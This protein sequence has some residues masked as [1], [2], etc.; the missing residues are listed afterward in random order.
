MARRAF[1][2]STFV[3]AVH[4]RLIA[5]HVLEQLGQGI[6]FASFAAILLIAVA[7]WQSMPALPVLGICGLLGLLI[8]GGLAVFRWP[9]RS[10]SASEADHQLGMNDLLTTTLFSNPSSDAAF[11]RAMVAMA[12]TKCGSHLPWEV[13]L[14]RMGIRNWSAV[15]LTMGVAVT[16]AVIP[17]SSAPSQA[18]DANIAVLSADH[19]PQL[20]RG[21]IPVFNNPTDQSA[22]NDAM[23]AASQ[24]DPVAAGIK[25]VSA[26]PGNGASTGVGGSST[27]S[28]Q[29]KQRLQEFNSAGR[30]QNA[31]GTFAGGGDASRNNGQRDEANN[32]GKT[33]GESPPQSV[34]QWAGTSNSELNSGVSKNAGQIP[35]QDRDLVREFFDRQ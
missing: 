33:I 27:T 10:T 8:G 14:R 31:R 3:D 34:P 7:N 28:A 22:S 12:D 5:V 24:S 4:R 30:S 18:I 13:V 35:P 6:L 21:P 17:M 32:G 25:P 16:L 19:P 1:T 9:T 23:T 29:S 15:A 11:F 2:A 20:N 26:K